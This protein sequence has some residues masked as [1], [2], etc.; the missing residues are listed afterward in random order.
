MERRGRENYDERIKKAR[1]D[2]NANIWG[3]YKD[4]RRIYSQGEMN[5]CARSRRDLS[6]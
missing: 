5:V 2:T 4:D 6:G 3:T 1:S